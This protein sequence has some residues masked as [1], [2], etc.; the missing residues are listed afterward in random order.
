MDTFGTHSG[1]ICC[2]SLV[3]LQT[4]WLGYKLFFLYF[5]F[6]PSSINLLKLPEYPTREELRDRL[7]VALQ[8]G[9]QGYGMA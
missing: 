1:F 3:L 9:S 2:T 5:V 6:T 4:K 8:C 7:V